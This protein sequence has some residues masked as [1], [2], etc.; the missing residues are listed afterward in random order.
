[1]RERLPYTTWHPIQLLTV[2]EVD[3]LWMEAKILK[4]MVAKR[5]RGAA[6]RGGLLIGAGSHVCGCHG[7]SVRSEVWY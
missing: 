1:M 7:V 5:G 3:I 6:I 4:H 2:V